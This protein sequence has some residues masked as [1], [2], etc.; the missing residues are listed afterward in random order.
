[1]SSLLFFFILALDH[2]FIASRQK[3]LREQPQAS[4]QT[5][6]QNRRAARGY[7]RTG[8]KMAQAL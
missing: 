2:K 1:M 7:R 5:K 6:K 3:F 4:L 8:Q